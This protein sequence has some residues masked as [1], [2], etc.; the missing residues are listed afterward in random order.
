MTG[1]RGGPGGVVF[2]GLHEGGLRSEACSKPG[3]GDMEFLVILLHAHRK[4]EISFF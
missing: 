1:V 3:K 2:S 4:G